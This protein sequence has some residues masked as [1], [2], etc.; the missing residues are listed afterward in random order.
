MFK[1][2]TLFFAILLFTGMA[3]A[4]K[5]QVSGNVKDTAT[6]ASV[7]NAVVT[8]QTPKDSILKA[9]TRVRED[10]SFLIKDVKPG[11][12]ILSVSH[13]TFGEYVDDIELNVAN[14]K[15]AL[16]ALTPKSKLLEAVIIKSGNP[17]RIKGDTT[18]YTAD[19]FK[20]S[21]NA[22]VE[23]LLKKLPGIQVDK[24]G[25]IKAM[26]QTVEKVLVDGEEF[27]G[28]DPGMAVK[29]LRAD[30]VKE[31]QVFDKKSEQ[32]EFT[33][34]D[35]GKTKKTINLKLK[36]DKKKGYFGKVDVAGGLQNDID[37]RYNDN[38]L[39]SS[40]KGKRKI[41]GFLLNGNTGQDGLN[42]QDEQKFGGEN[43]NMVVDEESGFTYFS[44]GGGAGDDEPRVDVN[45]GFIT[46]VNAGLQYSN[47]WNDKTNLNFSPKYNSQ[48][49]TNVQEMDRRT[50]GDS[51]LN[52]NSKTTSSVNRSNV[53]LKAIYDVK[54]D[55]ANTLK[56]TAKTNFYETES[57]ENSVGSTTGNKGVFLNSY[58]RS[59]TTN[60]DKQAISLE[61][62]FKHKF[63][64]AR[65]TLSI[66]ADWST[67]NTDGDRLQVSKNNAFGSPLDID[68]T[69]EFD[70]TT[71]KI[72][73]KVVYTEPLNKEFALELGYQM[74]FTNG[75]N[76]STTF[77][78]NDVTKKYD[79]KID[80]LSNYFD[81]NITQNIPS[82]K[83][84]YAKKKF[85]FNVGTGIGFVNFK[86][87]NLS[88]NET[89]QRDFTN[90]FPNV[91]FTYSYKANHSLNIRYNGSTRQPSIAQLQP[92][93]DNSN[94]FYQQIGNPNLQPTFT[95][96]FNVSHNSYNFIK[97]MWTYQSLNFNVENNAISSA[98][99]VSFPAKT[100]SQ[101]INVNGNYNLNLYAGLGFKVKK[102]DTRFNVNTN[103]GSNRFI[104]FR[105]GFKNISNNTNAGLS[106]YIS[107]SK[108]KK[109]DLGMSLGGD[110]NAQKATLGNIKTNFL[111]NRIGFDGTVYYKKVWSINSNVEYFTRQKTENLK[112][113]SNGLWNAKLQR[114]F[115]KDEFT[116]YVLVRDILNQNRGIDRDFGFNTFTETRNER[117]QRY[118]MVGFTWNFKNKAATKK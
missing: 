87:K 116:F 31:V 32:A 22:N 107:K 81:Q 14:E 97:D 106:F 90:F 96:S 117:L 8:L 56:I 115:K 91:N 69:R 27:F 2:F 109:Y 94:V 18:I 73:S 89:T 80:N 99:N 47:K 15:M 38:I 1:K 52:E 102:I 43:D 13:P 12:Y 36:E 46:N 75:T 55:S 19:S 34:I 51:V 86:L 7:K 20:V 93:I 4:Q 37:H 105:N 40:F 24:N 29:N 42:W 108:D 48:R 85:K 58:D 101:A 118:W 33:G 67:L 61:A 17:I 44:R 60:S 16:I 5:I 23:E 111:T 72:S 100:T 70:K 112:A 88:S 83:I 26:G 3:F 78:F 10:G 53:K 62:I 6:K 84:N 50:S 9:F 21:A 92:L 82:A 114:T 65:R 76:N 104:S 79:I 30:A 39:L 45:N 66:N 28:D 63:K 113:I 110:F 25:Q 98:E 57:F 95:N 77:D 54:I 11:K 41:T 68:Q 59:L 35:D 74:V 103:I 49:Y 71:G 64:K